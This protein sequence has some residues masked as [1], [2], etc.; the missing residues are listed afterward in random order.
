LTKYVTVS[1]KVPVELR[2][3]MRELG[4]Q[5]SSVLRKAIEEEVRRKEVERIKEAVKE[6]KPL[7][8]RLSM[9]DV[10]RSI[11]EDRESH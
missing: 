2:E 9:E 1:V 8:N 10:V 4:I 7:L 6:L 11:R 3:K 5:A